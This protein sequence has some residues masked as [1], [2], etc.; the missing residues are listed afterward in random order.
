MKKDYRDTDVDSFW[1]RDGVNLKLEEIRLD[2]RTFELKLSDFLRAE[3]LGEEM[4]I[5]AGHVAGLAGHRLMTK[6]RRR[7]PGV[8]STA[9]IELVETENGIVAAEEK[10]GLSV[11]AM[12]ALFAE[13]IDYCARRKV[14]QYAFWRKA[15]KDYWD[16]RLDEAKKAGDKRNL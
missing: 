14:S 1:S 12:K 15:L 11:H 9:E 16:F 10:R 7:K 13:I 6:L 3:Q 2:N 5:P 8:P 4:G